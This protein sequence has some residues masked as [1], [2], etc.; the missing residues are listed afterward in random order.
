M[1]NIRWFL[2]ELKKSVGKSK[3]YYENT[4]KEVENKGFMTVWFFEKA[5]MRVRKSKESVKIELKT[6][7]TKDLD[8]GNQL[9]LKTDKDWIVTYYNDDVIEKILNNV[10]KVYEKC[11]SEA[12]DP[13]GCCSKYL[14]CSDKRRCIQPDRGMVRNCIYKGHL[15][16]GRIFYGKNRNI[17]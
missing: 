6:R 14:E 1:K 17:T 10:A 16:E 5:V 15:N 7:F 2:D 12:P 13:F 9:K 11:Y 3:C 4:I 8:I